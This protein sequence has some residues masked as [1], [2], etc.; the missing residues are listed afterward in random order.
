M[1]EE[2]RARQASLKERHS[3][4]LRALHSRYH[5]IWGQILKT[6]YQNSRFAH[7]VRRFAM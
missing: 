1:L 6:G 5:P 2:L 3:E 4:E 7:Q